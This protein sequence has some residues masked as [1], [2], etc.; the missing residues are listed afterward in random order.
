MIAPAAVAFLRYG[1][2]DSLH[3][4]TARVC[5][6]CGYGGALYVALSGTSPTDLPLTFIAVLVTFKVLEEVGILLLVDEPQRDALPS[7]VSYW[8][9]GRI[10]LW[11]ERSG[12]SPLRSPELLGTRNRD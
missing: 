10:S 12:S 7:I 5:A 6:V 11:N 1:R 9:A 2:A 3:T 4:H 8:K